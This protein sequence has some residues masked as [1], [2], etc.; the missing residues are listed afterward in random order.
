MIDGLF[1]GSAAIVILEN[2][3]QNP[4]IIPS[5]YTL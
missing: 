5:E 1:L 4:K 2:T 3:P